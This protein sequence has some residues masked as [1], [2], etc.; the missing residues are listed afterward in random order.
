MAIFDLAVDSKL[1]TCDLTRLRVRDIAHGK[2]VSPRAIVMQLKTHRPV[3]FE[4]AE[5]T[6][7]AV[8]AWIRLASFEARTSCSQVGLPTPSI[9]PPDSTHG[10]SKPR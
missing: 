10:S 2:H 7:S 3:Q 8:E 4:I 5:Q 9:F 6:R 1:R